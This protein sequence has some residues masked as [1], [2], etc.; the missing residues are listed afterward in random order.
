MT[1]TTLK[2]E[3][4]SWH[5]Q[6]WG[7]W[8]WVET[9]IKLVGIVIAVYG[10]ISILPSFSLGLPLNL[11]LIAV[12]VLA[13]MT[14]MSL[15]IVTIRFGQREIIAFA[16]AIL[17]AVGHISA[18]L[19]LLQA[20]A[21]TFYPTVGFALAYLLGELVKIQFLRITGYSESGRDPKAMQRIPI[22]FGTAYL[23]IAIFAWF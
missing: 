21:Q 13:L 19:V 20:S 1:T 4:A 22:V 3:S 14:L 12:I 18:L 8:G 7:V 17:S 5:V 2:S 9:I 10:L 15:F 16:F 11:H 23:L 6:N